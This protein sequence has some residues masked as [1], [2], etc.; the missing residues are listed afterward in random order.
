MKIR[1]VFNTEYTTM[2]MKKV[3]LHLDTLR[4]SVFCKRLNVRDIGYDRQAQND[5]L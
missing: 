1:A 4:A 5:R 2:I 3:Y